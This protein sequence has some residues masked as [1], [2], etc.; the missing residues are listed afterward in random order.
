MREQFDPKKFQGMNTYER[1]CATGGGHSRAD[2][3]VA[4]GT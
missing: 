1:M 4:G 3:K 2:G